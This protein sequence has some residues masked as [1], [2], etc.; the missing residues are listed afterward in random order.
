M[1]EKQ[2]L[3]FKAIAVVAGIDFEGKV[4]G[5]YVRDHSVTGEDFKIFLR[6]L[7]C[8]FMHPKETIYLLLDN[9]GVHHM[10]D[11]T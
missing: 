11:V 9:L 1:V 10:K 4:Y 7:R 2:R 6:K 8:Q 5:L 3:A